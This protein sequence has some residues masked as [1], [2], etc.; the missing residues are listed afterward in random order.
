MNMLIWGRVRRL[1]AQTDLFLERRGAGE[2]GKGAEGE[3][4]REERGDGR[5]GGREGGGDRGRRCERV[6]GEDLA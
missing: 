2:R 3:R 6:Y 1:R 5:G 4:E